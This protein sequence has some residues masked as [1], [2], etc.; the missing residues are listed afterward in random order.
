MMRVLIW[1]ISM[2][3]LLMLTGCIDQALTPEQSACTSMCAKRLA[4]C[5]A[6]CKN[7]SQCCAASL[8]TTTA[9]NYTKYKHQQCVQ[10]VMIA[11]DLQSYRD[12]LQCRKMTCDCK[13]DYR[14]CVQ[15]CTGLVHKRLQVEP[16]CC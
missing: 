5:D 13:A 14:V 8:A 11:R 4:S 3:L 2:M 16:P 9:K 7:N 12:P 6:A 1:S 15:S 10:G